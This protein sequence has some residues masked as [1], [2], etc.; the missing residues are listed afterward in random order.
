MVA[1]GSRVVLRRQLADKASVA[2]EIRRM[3]P[4]EFIEVLTRPCGTARCPPLDAFGKKMLAGKEVTELMEKE[5]DEPEQLLDKL[6]PPSHHSL[7]H[8]IQIGRS[9]QQC[10]D[11]RDAQ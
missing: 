6:A 3:E 11:N 7:S 1:A 4:N 10:G 8:H 5:G 2:A 9:A